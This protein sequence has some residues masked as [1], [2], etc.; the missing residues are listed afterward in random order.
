MFGKLFMSGK[1]VIEGR[2]AGPV[3]LF[4]FFLSP[5]L[6]SFGLTLLYHGMRGIMRLGGFVA[7]GGPYEIAHPA[8][9]WVWLM[10]VSVLLLILPVFTSI[11]TGSRISGPNI[12]ALS[13]PAI[14]ISLGWN[15]SEFG[16]GIGMG[17]GLVA[18][19]VICAVLFI[20]MGII[21]LIF[22]LRSFF[23]S[24]KG[25]GDTSGIEVAEHHGQSGQ[26]SWG[27]SIILQAALCAAGI[28]LGIFVFACLGQ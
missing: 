16:F 7:S 12:M 13:W 6:F 5:F 22:I 27:T 11:F 14:F 1:P 8:P 9:D 17:G 25:R 2:G 3:R 19:W 18:G 28:W 24:L 26:L 23:M 20:L 15:F 21:P 10:P 4:L